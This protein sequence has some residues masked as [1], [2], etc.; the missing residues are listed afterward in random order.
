MNVNICIGNTNTEA[1][2][3]SGSVCTIINKS[4]ANAVVSDCQESFWVQLPGMQEFKT[5]SNDLL[6]TI[7]VIKTSVHFNGWVAT[8]V[9]VT[10]FEDG[11]RLIIGR[12]RF[13]QLDLS[14]TQ[15]KNVSSIDQNQCLIKK[16][17][18]F[19]FPDLISRIG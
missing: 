16:Q 15:T 8:D 1:F 6:K 12:D 7:G 11:H 13:S 2:V 18:A 17:T 19:N 5:F 10:V 14:L 9:N 4:V 3:D